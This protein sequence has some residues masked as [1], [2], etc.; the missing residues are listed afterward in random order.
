[1]LFPT[2]KPGHQRPGY[3]IEVVQVTVRVGDCSYLLFELK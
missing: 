3:Q 1:M 2:Y